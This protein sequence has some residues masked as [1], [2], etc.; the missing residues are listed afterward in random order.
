MEVPTRYTLLF[1]CLFCISIGIIDFQWMVAGDSLSD[2]YRR[3]L[4]KVFQTFRNR[5]YINENRRVG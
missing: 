3:I 1:K 5:K 4:R 2:R